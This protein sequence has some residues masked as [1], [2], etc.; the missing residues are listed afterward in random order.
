M[1]AP[2]SRLF[3]PTLIAVGLVAST[4]SALGAP[5]VPMLSRDLHSSVAVTQW[6][7]T[8]TLLVGAV[9][10]PLIGRMGDGPH[11][12]RVLV[13]GLGVVSVGGLVAACAPHIG[14]LIAG[15]ALQGVGLALMP[16]AIASARESLSPARAPGVIAALSVTVAVGIGLGYPLTGLIAHVAGAP[17]AF[18]AGA[19]ASVAAMLLSAR[20]VPS[21]APST[22]PA[23]LDLTGAAI[24][25]GG[26]LALLLS[27]ENTV[28][29]GW[30]APLTLALAAAAA[31]LLWWWGR[32][33][34]RCAHPLVDLRLMTH[35]PVMSAN[36]TALLLGTTMFIGV[37]LIA[38][39]VQL[40]VGM[41]YNAFVAGLTLLPLSVLSVGG[42]RAT[43]AVT[44][45]AGPRAVLPIGALIIAAGLVFFAVSG[46]RLWHAFVTMGMVGLGVGLTFA[47]MPGMIVRAVPA[48][49]TSSAI[50]VY[51]VARYVGFALGSGVAM[52]LLRVFAGADASPTGD[53]YRA[54]FG[55]GGGLCV[56]AAAVAWLLAGAGR[57]ASP[58]ASAPTR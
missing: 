21:T 50:S 22:D 47:A 9:L 45:V 7:L 57:G 39:I 37:S 52:T 28:R 25:G 18:A 26:L 42:T 32:H 56:V 55:V 8:A 1:S 23:P 54:A 3:V 19:L 14:V 27:L 6:S 17:G 31:V 58:S 53:D 49:H 44:R 16:L 24:V 15:R 51:Q 38:Q 13:A 41:G 4:V 48:H 11:R 5:L 12:R 34:L 35:R 43:A 36:V 20:Y 10:S 2:P 30:T 29:Q 33:C 46:T 40:P